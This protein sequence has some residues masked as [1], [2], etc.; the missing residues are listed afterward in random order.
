MPNQGDASNPL[1]KYGSSS[2][3]YPV[4]VLQVLATLPLRMRRGGR[5]LLLL[6]VALGCV[7][8]AP[9]SA[10]AATHWLCKPGKKDNPCDVSL[11]TARYS[12]AGERLGV[13]RIQTP[14]R[15]KFDCFY[16]YPTVSDQQGPTASFRIDPELR[17]IA[18]Y[19]AARYTS[20]CR[21]FAPVYR[22]VTLQGILGIAPP[23]PAD[24]ELGYNDVRAAWRDYLRH[25]NKG[26]GV[27]FVGHSQGSYVLR[28]LL[29]NEVDPKPRVRK[30]MVSALLLGGNVLVKEGRDT[31]GD[32]EKLRACRSR[33]QFGCVVAFSVFNEA[34]PADARFGRT[35]E[36]G[37]E[38]LCTNPA[39]LGGGS[40]KVTAIQPAEPFAPGTTIGA[41]V[42][43]LG[44][45]T[46][47]TSATWRAF[48]GSYRA[49]CS[50]AGGAD[51]LMLSSLGGATVFHP[52]PT[53]QWGLHLIDAN[54]ALGEQ[55]ALIR[56]QS[57][58]WRAARR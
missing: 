2:S 12:P 43:V 55:V 17:S 35:D 46:P 41:A 18:L 38:V 50:S 22:Q 9:A 10:S 58:L 32:F 24:R 48:P 47:R 14:R 54:V 20:E 28:E 23:S 51:V 37:M 7:V 5:I 15:P 52:S 21:V 44:L 6:A 13:D 30:L 53:P 25:H 36:E 42:A 27:V 16:V 34:V 39:A 57:A 8:A 40:A 19:Q 33:A 4:Q 1:H 56:H 11:A 29:A 45:P 49:R 3:G 26:R 31:G